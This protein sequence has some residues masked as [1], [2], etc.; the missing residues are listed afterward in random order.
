M[1]AFAATHVVKLLI[2]LAA[3]VVI[4]AGPMPWVLLVA[5]PFLVAALLGSCQ[6]KRFGRRLVPILVIAFVMGSAALWSH[7][8]DSRRPL[9]AAL[10]AVAAGCVLV[11]FGEMTSLS[12][13]LRGMSALGVPPL[14]TGSLALMLRS[15]DVLAEERRA[16]LRSRA[17]RGGRRSSWWGDW[18]ERAGLVGLILVRAA[19]RSERVHRAMSARGWSTERSR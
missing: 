5:A 8:G 14:L 12:E 7:A 9:E 18:R 19:D 4:A 11:A 15:I 2:L 16:L 10:R 13:V 6:W 17:A 3:L 1:N